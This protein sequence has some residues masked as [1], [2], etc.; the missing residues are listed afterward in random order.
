MSKTKNFLF[1]ALLFIVVLSSQTAA[2]A[3]IG[4]NEAKSIAFQHAGLSEK[5]TSALSVKQYE[6]HGVKLYDIMF[7]SG[8]VKYNYEIGA[9]S[10]E[11]ME[12]KRRNTGK[13]IQ[14]PD[15]GTQDYI[16]FEKA[17]S[18]ALVHANVPES[19]IRKYEAELDRNRGRVVYEIE[20]DHAWAEYEYEIDAE[21]G[22]IVR[23]ESEYD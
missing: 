5:E 14:K 13:A 19:E 16:G 15:D 3:D 8:G 12:Y 2:V 7:S 6:K 21:T 10:G 22:E 1:A 17:K 18:I 4:E 9:I 23:W 11:I 20:F